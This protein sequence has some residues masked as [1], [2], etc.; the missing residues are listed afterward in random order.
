MK[1]TC[2]LPRRQG[3]V[4]NRLLLKVAGVQAPLNNLVNTH[5]ARVIRSSLILGMALTITA[6]CQTQR[7]Q[8]IERDLQTLVQ[9]QD[10]KERARAAGY[11]GRYPEP[12]STKRVV[13]GLI[14]ALKD[15]DATVRE[16]A[17]NGLGL[18]KNRAAIQPLFEV[19]TCDVTVTVR[20]AA[21]SSLTAVGWQPRSEQEKAWH[22]VSLQL[23]EEAHS[24][25]GA[26]SR[27]LRSAIQCAINS[28]EKDG[29][30]HA[31]ESKV[32]QDCLKECGA[33]A[34]EPLVESLSSHRQCYNKADV[35]VRLGEPSVA[36]L[37]AAMDSGDDI[38]RYWAAYALG[39]L[40]DKRAIP[41]L[42]TTLN[43]QNGC[44]LAN[45]VTALLSLGWSASTPAEAAAF[46]VGTNKPEEAGELGPIAVNALRAGM[47]SGRSA[48]RNR[49]AQVLRQ[50]GWE[51]QTPDDR[52][53]YLIALGHWEQAAAVGEAALA[54]SIMSLGVG[55]I[56]V[57]DEVRENAARVLGRLGNSRA[58]EPLLDVVDI[59]SR[60][61]VYTP[62]QD[63]VAVAEALAKLGDSHGV[64]FLIK[65]L[66]NWDY[67]PKA[68]KALEELGWKPSSDAERIRFLAGCRD[69]ERL[70]D[71]WDTTKTVLLADIRS[72][73]RLTSRNGA[74]TLIAI[75]NED[76]IRE[77]VSSTHVGVGSVY[78]KEIY[79]NSG[80][81]RLR[82]VAADWICE[83]GDM[84]GEEKGQAP[85]TWG[86]WRTTQ[87]S[88]DP[89]VNSSR[90]I[91]KAVSIKPGYQQRVAEPSPLGQQNWCRVTIV[92]PSDYSV[93]VAVRAGRLGQDSTYERG[94]DFGIAAHSSKFIMVPPAHYDIYFAFATE[95]TALYQGD[96][97]S[98][99]AGYSTT[100]K[101]VRSVDGNYRIRRVK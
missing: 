5:R 20:K 66:T 98:V 100:I 3:Y 56:F 34:V 26:A 71:N 57:D 16:E 82:E 45:T 60:F 50:L 29:Y 69:L 6:G 90:T 91:Q 65:Y 44:V 77:L 19:M 75:G 89:A 1:S 72:N 85:I 28:L 51:P 46:L 81:A 87:S 23:W 38:V 68:A 97:F 15:K 54:T 83:L 40:H 99:A 32:A 42:M 39:D 18:L 93:A 12:Y 27:P 43:T 92:N 4:A 37:I 95:P 33:L 41:V 64:P 74:S 30:R 70:L 49:A 10:A 73:D 24:L 84:V 55:D 86:A 101:L 9:S 2:D 53:R 17:A 25:G 31:S 14:N 79:L 59:D 21:A 48:T 96:S 61:S 78:V 67:A 80:H 35:L 76:A 11:L 52:A 47:T 62:G 7:N 13:E 8:T 58:I 63:Y 36:P 22:L 88:S 94:T